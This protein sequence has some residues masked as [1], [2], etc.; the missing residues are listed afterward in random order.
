MVLILCL[1]LAVT[2]GN[3][4]TVRTL[5][6]LRVYPQ[7]DHIITND[8]LLLLVFRTT[9]GSPSELIMFAP[10]DTLSPLDLSTDA[11]RIAAGEKITDDLPDRLILEKVTVQLAQY[12]Q[13]MV[14]ATDSFPFSAGVLGRTLFATDTIL[15]V[16][17]TLRDRNASIAAIRISGWLSTVASIGSVR[18]ESKYQVIPVPL[19]PGTNVIRYGWLAAGAGRPSAMDSITAFYSLDL[20]GKLAPAGYDSVSFHRSSVEINCVPCHAHAPPSGNDATAAERRPCLVCHG[21]L[22]QQRWVHGPIASNDCHKC[23]DGD[24]MSG[25]VLRYQPKDEKEA[26]FTCHK[27]VLDNS[28]GKRVV[29]GPFGGGRCNDCHSAHSAP[30]RYQLR[31]PVNDLCNSCHS[32]KREHNHPVV[33]HPVGWKSDPRSPNRELSCVSCHD[34]HASDFANLLATPDGYFALCQ[35]CHKK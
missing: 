4:Q 23:H 32:G 15:S 20:A 27:D 29:H 30:N 9:G 1:G 19:R 11:R 21:G 33:F 28:K 13:P 14:S 12:H 25:Y 22:L 6:P 2:S 31:R 7:R 16:T 10:W 8:N 5:P 18:C 3:G 26:C 35:G 17:R 24:P 34:P